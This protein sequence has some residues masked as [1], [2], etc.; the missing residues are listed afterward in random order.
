MPGELKICQLAYQHVGL[1]ITISVGSLTEPTLLWEL[2]YLIISVEV[3]NFG[4]IAAI[5]VQKEAL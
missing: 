1:D 3:R 2:K 5:S 4:V